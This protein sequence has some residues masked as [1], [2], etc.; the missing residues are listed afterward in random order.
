M[1]IRVF[2]LWTLVFQFVR[3]K[4]ALDHKFSGL[5]CDPLRCQVPTEV[6]SNTNICSLP[7]SIGLCLAS[8]PR[9]WYNKEFK[10]CTSFNYGGC[11]GN[12]NN[13]QSE[14]VCRAVCSE[15][16]KSQGSHLPCSAAQV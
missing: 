11:A 3:K 13:F 9:W 8:I 10:T 12:N 4:Q 6:P 16:C 14:A 5:F 2:A 7:M 1:C 15:A